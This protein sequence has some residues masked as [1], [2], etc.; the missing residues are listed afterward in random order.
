MATDPPPELV[1]EID[2]RSPSLDKFPIFA[3]L[4]IAEVWHYHKQVLTVFRLQGAV[5]E[6]RQA[7]EVLPGIAADT[8]TRLIANS[9]QM[10]RT[11]WLREVRE[12]TRPLRQ[13]R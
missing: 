7:S 13:G 1:I 11:E 8:L 4:G 3:G 9:Q 5:Y 10:K 12:S 6:P 2:I